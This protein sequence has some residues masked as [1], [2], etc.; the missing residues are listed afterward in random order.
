MSLLGIKCN[1][2]TPLWPQGNLEVERFNQPL[3]KAIRAACVENKNWKQEIQI[4]LLNYRST[5]HT[6]NKISPSELLYN[7]PIKGN[8]P[9]IT[10]KPISKRHRE[11]E[12][13]DALGKEK[14]KEYGDKR[15]HA[16][17][18]GICVGDSV[19][20]KQEK[21]SKFSASFESIPYTVISRNRSRVAATREDGRTITRNASF[22]KKYKTKVESDSDDDDDLFNDINREDKETTVQAN[23]G[24]RYPVRQRRIP[25]R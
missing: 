3:G 9:C 8:L 17:S 25:Q 11:A 16:K 18:S 10:K 13:N 12:R 6:T 1:P 21:K 7:R 19:L 24:P 23:R 14:M 5:P 15:R 4:F 22:F 20:L 2:S